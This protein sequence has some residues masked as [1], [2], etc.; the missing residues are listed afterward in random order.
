MKKYITS[1][2]VILALTGFQTLSAQSLK[3]GIKAGAD[4]KKI[5]GKSFSDEFSYG[6]HLGAQ[7]ELGLTSK[8]GIQ[9]EVYFSQVNI[10]TASNFSQIYQFNKISSVKLQYIN[11]PILLSFKPN[12]YVALQ[13]GP[14]YG[15][16]MN[17]DKTLLANGKEAFK[18]GDFSMLGGVQ[19]NFGKVRL[20]GRYGVGLSEL[21][22]IDNKDKWKS[23][24]VQL[25]LA[26]S[27]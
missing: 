25:G 1:L 5:S 18:S 16:L 9:P 4:I 10:D 14:Q 17:K 19:L 12:K 27:F 3:L 23:Q 6:Y 7:L 13:V 11:I 21:N 8:F 26:L 2:A 15:I 24:T 22:D 20:Y